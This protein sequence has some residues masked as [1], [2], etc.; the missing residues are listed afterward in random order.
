M[1]ILIYVLLVVILAL[2][3]GFVVLL[4]RRADGRSQSALADT[5]QRVEH[6]LR[7]QERALANLVHERLAKSEETTGKIVTAPDGPPRIDTVV[8]CPGI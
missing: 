2:G 4:T 8:S 1:D 7:E 6:S 5:V 3:A